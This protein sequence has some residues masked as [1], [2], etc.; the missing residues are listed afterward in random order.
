MTNQLQRIFSEIPERYE[1]VN[2]ALT[3]GLD[4]VWRRSLAA[5][6]AAV[7]GRAPRVLDMCTGTGETAAYVARRL[8]PDAL[9]VGADFTV[10]MMIEGRR[11]GRGGIAF[12]AA[13]ATALPFPDGSF[14][15]VTISF[16]TRNLNVTREDL[17][18]AFREFRRVLKPGGVFLNLE[19]SR[20]PARIIRTLFDL[21]ARFIVPRLGRLLSGSNTGYAYLSNTMRRFY[22]AEELAAL[23][24]EAG[25]S[26]ARFRRF[27]FGLVALHE[28]GAAA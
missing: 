17:L 21:Y 6:A 15:A 20:P 25:F 10:P 16:A 18:A 28:A 23:L 13:E 4:A 3:F 24:R 27:H 1:L 22:D 14:D 7:A 26:D 8:G 11:R 2:H 19:T 12:V 5:R 9:V